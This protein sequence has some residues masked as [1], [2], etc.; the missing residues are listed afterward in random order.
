[1]KSLIKAALPDWLLNRVR[2]ARQQ[3]QRSATV[4]DWR[5]A[6]GRV[7][8]RQPAVPARKLLVFPADTGN[9]TGSLGDDAM[10]TAAVQHFSALNPSVSVTLLCDSDKAEG[11]VR[12]IGF[13]PLRIPPKKGMASAMLALLQTGEYDALV[14]LGAD[15]M[16]GY[17]GVSF[18]ENILM[19]VDLAARSGVDTMLLGFSFNNHPAADL[20]P[21]YDGCDSR[22][23]FNLRDE[24]SLE[25]F[26]RFTAT[27]ATL[28]ADSAFTL[29]PSN[30]NTD[31]LSW[32][33]AQ[34]EAGRKVVAFNVHP[35][36]I[37]NASPT[38]IARVIE[39]S[40]DA[41]TR[42]SRSHEIAWLLTPHDY[43]GELS[44]GACLHPIYEKLKTD[45]TVIARYFDGE[46]RASTLKALA[47][48][49]D[50]VVT[51]RMHFAIAALGMG[52][53]ALCLTYQD[54]FE[55]LFRHFDLSADLLLSPSI[56]ETEGR[57]PEALAG[58]VDNLANLQQM[59]KSNLP[60]VA[61]LAA[62]NFGKA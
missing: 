36:L 45:D 44:D 7:L 55:G 53:P 49:L 15:I 51:G 57:L 54:K 61:A 28:V 47:G 58:F 48:H 10:I 17:Y 56:F 38:Q 42:T 4:A 34:R 62:E 30:V 24:V 46:H 60:K 5:A 22:V 13:T 18:I 43:R 2:Q 21:F 14:V 41:I 23:R 12:A 39:K 31:T 37:K 32:I 40:A 29:K 33:T 16:D 19:T 59:V 26:R 25:R 35:L 52:V 50:G 9:I 20:K 1:M 27:R 6:Q 3:V 11:I 8:P